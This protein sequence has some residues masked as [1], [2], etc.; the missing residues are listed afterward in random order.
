MNP[1]PMP[2]EEVRC[3]DSGGERTR[4]AE[5]CGI[6]EERMPDLLLP[7]RQRGWEKG[8]MQFRMPC[9]LGE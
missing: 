1:N 5:G 3:E 7:Q 4:S 2:P 8:Q 9:L 6:L